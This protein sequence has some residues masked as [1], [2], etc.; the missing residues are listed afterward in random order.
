MLT[1]ARLTLLELLRRRLVHAMVLLTALGLTLTTW[2]F[3]QLARFLAILGGDGNDLADQVQVAL[4]ASQLLILILFMFSFVFALAAV[5]VAAPAVASDVESGIAHALLARPLGRRAYLLGRWLGLALAVG[6]YAAAVSVAQLAAVALT[7]G[8]LAPSPASAV[9]L[10]V[11]QAVASA[12]LA[13]V[14]GTRLPA[15]TAGV[16][17]G[18]LFAL[19][20]VAGVV[21]GIG[22]ALGDAALA[23]SGPAT[24]LLMPTDALWRG[25]VY[26]LEPPVV[27]LGASGAGPGL[28]AF[29]FIVT[30]PIPIAFVAWSVAWVGIVLALGVVA[31]ERRDV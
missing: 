29:P 31:F 23:A 1:I 9:A 3:G 4:I 6:G 11:L 21:G 16:A 10:L 27:L 24:A 25:A 22:R 17:A 8:Y 14:L 2:G 13:L 19:A 15:L 5:F 26:A 12:T 20:W 28:A 18:V 7:A 30:E